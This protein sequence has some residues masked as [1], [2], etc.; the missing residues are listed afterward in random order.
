M[1]NIRNLLKDSNPVA[2][3]RTDELTE[4]AQRELT[5]LIGTSAP[6]GPRP[7][8]HAWRSRRRWVPALAAAVVIVASLGVGAALRSDRVDPPSSSSDEP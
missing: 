8:E 3:R 5:D 1:R 7:S 6:A 2:E 4:R